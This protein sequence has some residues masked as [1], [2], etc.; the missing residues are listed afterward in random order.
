MAIMTKTFRST[1]KP[2]TATCGAVGRSGSAKP[3]WMTNIDAQREELRQLGYDER[4]YRMWRYFLLSLAGSDR[5]RR[6]PL[7]QVVCSNKGLDGGYH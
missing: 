6:N 2:F 3:I 7:W 4:I 5:A 1:T